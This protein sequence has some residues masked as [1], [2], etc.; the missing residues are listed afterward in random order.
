M[1]YIKELGSLAIA[2]RMKRIVEKLNH[3][4][5][6]IYQSEK[7]DFEPLLMPILK[8]LEN[9]GPLQV[10]QIADCLGISQ[11]ASTQLC[12]LLEKKKLLVSK[13]RKEDQR[14]KEV[15]LNHDGIVIIQ[16][17]SPVWHEIQRAVDDMINNS[18]NLLVAIEAFE[19]QYNSKPLRERVMEELERKKKSN[20]EMIAYDDSLDGYFKKLNF[21][22]ISK[23]FIIEQTDKWACE[24]P[25][26]YIIDKGGYIYFSK[27]KNEI[28]GTYA[29]IKHDKNVFEIAKMAVTES[30]QGKGIGKKMLE[31]AIGKAHKMKLKKIILYSNTNLTTALNLYIN[32][33]FRVI[34]KDDY[35]NER[36][37]I[38]MELIL[39]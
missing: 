9:K 22:W 35:H 37:N 5:K 32:K 19:K 25:K 33:G 14:S 17:L 1:D 4:V 28:V 31:H 20:I 16:R 7:I 10:T 21:E 36:A 29:L 18:D 34:P 26:A 39:G 23:Y 12:N 6:T 15:S 2:S 30:F 8:L 27:W 13:T 38:K 24:H 3:D 11:P